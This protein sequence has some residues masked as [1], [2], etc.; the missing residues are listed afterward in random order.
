MS[1]SGTWRDRS[2][3]SGSHEAA[4]T[5]ETHDPA[6]ETSPASALPIPPVAPAMPAIP[7]VI[8]AAAPI[9]RR[10]V[11]GH[12]GRLGQLGD[13]SRNGLDWMGTS[14]TAGTAGGGSVSS[15]ISGPHSRGPQSAPHGATPLTTLV[16]A[17]LD[18]LRVRGYRPKT[19][20]GYETKLRRFTDWAAT[21]DATELRHFDAALAKRYIS[22]L[23][24]DHRWSTHPNHRR[25]AQ[26]LLSPVA[27]SNYVRD[28]K[29]FSVWLGQEHYT[30]GDVLADV[31]KP[32]ADETPITPFPDDEI[33]RIF[34]S[35][36]TTDVFDLRDFVILHTLWD[37]GLRVGELVALTLDDVDL[38]HGEIR[39]AHTKFGKWRDIGFGTQTHKYLMRYLSLGRPQPAIADERH[40]FLAHDGYPMNEGTVQRL[41]YRLSKRSGVHIHAHRFRHTF[42]VNMLKNGTDIRTLQKLMGHASI[43]ILT[44]Y[45]NLASA[46]AIAAHRTNSPADH[47]YAQRPAGPRRLPIARTIP[48]R[49]LTGTRP[50]VRDGRAG[51]DG[52][53]W[54]DG[55]RPRPPAPRRYPD[56]PAQPERW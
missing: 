2:G 51:R 11:R 48:Q 39:V 46:D 36:D 52:H 28:L 9:R 47:F 14:A 8:P 22:Y 55:Q 21:V 15:R 54:S 7:A 20:I 19:I 29:V 16:R 12:R 4:E 3:S 30:P 31:R 26:P 42:A 23:Q 41:C 38:Q 5:A 17:Y 10:N 32:K 43:H 13:W 50:W 45:L 33:Q 27:I 1:D 49:R 6:P 53:D 24:Q 34:A 56:W 18:D 25:A 40:F 35:L 44:R 37:T